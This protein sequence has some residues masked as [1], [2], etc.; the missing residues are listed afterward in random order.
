[1]N[2]SFVQLNINVIMNY[3]DITTPILELLNIYIYKT[4]L[5]ITYV[6]ENF[7]FLEIGQNNIK[8]RKNNLFFKIIIE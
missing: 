5:S 8:I 1:M 4:L 2:L 7:K 3:N 6:K